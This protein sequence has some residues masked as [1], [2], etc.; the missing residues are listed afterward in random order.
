MTIRASEL[1]RIKF[2]VFLFLRI[3][4]LL[5]AILSRSSNVRF[6][7]KSGHW[8]ILWVIQSLITIWPSFRR[9]SPL[10]LKHVTKTQSQ[11]S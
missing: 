11:I 1:V 4:V 3:N 7:G 10:A 9:D 6:E 2:F 5:G 8:M